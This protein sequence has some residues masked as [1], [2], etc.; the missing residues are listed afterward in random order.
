MRVLIVEDEALIAYDLSDQLTAEG[1][2]VIGP[3]MQVAEAQA[4]LSSEVCDAAVLDVNLGNGTTSEPI[5]VQLKDRSI[6]FI[7][8]SGYSSDQHPAVFHDS[9]LIL[10]PIRITVLIQELRKL[11]V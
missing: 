4:L 11:P 6:P 10:K 3:A 5:A 8:A 7:V 1:F 2:T 9:P